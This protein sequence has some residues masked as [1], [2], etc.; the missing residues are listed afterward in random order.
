LFGNGSC[1]GKAPQ[2]ELGKE[3]GDE[4]PPGQELPYRVFGSVAQP[5]VFPPQAVLQGL[6][7][8]PEF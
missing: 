7:P 3:A 1:N 2:L 4:D 5:P 6:A 8:R